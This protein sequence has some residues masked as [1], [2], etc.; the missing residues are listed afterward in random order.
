MIQRI[1]T[2]YLFASAILSALAVFVLPMYDLDGVTFAA[3]ANA[4]TFSGFGGSMA[5][6]S[7]SILLYNNRN[8][9]LLIVRL[10]MLTSLVVLGALI[11]I[12]QDEGATASWGVVV[13]FINIVLA[14]MASKGIQKDEAKVRS[15]DRLR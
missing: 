4:S 14:F 3:T 5:L 1:Q 2:L 8:L 7:G 6:L 15:L 13:P 10:G 11:W 12:I 9:Q